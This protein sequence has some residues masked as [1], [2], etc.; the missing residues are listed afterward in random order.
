MC[1]TDIGSGYPSGAGVFGLARRR[2]HRRILGGLSSRL[3]LRAFST[4]FRVTRETVR[5]SSIGN[6]G[7][8]VTLMTSMFLK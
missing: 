1:D 4:A 2:H 3:F 6:M 7:K 5:C 8:A